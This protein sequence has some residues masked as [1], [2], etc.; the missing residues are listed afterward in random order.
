MDIF[1]KATAAVLIALVV[2][3][4]IGKQEKDI[5]L[6]LSIAVCCMVVTAAVTY[7]Q[8]V[9]RFF[10]RLQTIGQ[11]DAGMLTVLIKA[12]GIALL[13]E[14]TGLICADAGNAALG[15]VLQILATAVILWLSI[16]LFER[17]IELIENILGAV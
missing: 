3:L 12:V 8:P 2:G 16:P 13:S 7:L 9:I 14:I 15:K 10:E 5:S 1:L 11:L 17:L 4:S 6:L